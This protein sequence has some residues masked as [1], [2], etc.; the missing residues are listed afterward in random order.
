M[1]KTKDGKVGPYNFGHKVSRA[2]YLNNSSGKMDHFALI[3]RLK[4]C[5]SFI[6]YANSGK[7]LA[8]VPHN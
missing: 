3:F 4:H 8:S 2:K 7:R 1:M 5:S 6:R